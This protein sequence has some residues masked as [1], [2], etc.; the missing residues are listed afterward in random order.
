[1]GYMASQITSI[2][3]VYPTVYSRADRRKQ[4]SSVSLAFVRGIHRVPVNS[5]HKWPVTRK[6]FPFDDVFMSIEHLRASQKWAIRYSIALHYSDVI[7]SA[8]ASQINF[9][10][11]VCATICLDA[12]PRKKSKLRV[13]GFFRGIHQWSV[14]FPHR[15]PVTRKMFPF[16]DVFML[17]AWEKRMI[18]APP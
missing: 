15:G 12:D 10:S 11:I 13:T 5:P 3:I 6:M 2:T 18:W 17:P 8:I 16:G 9:V 7:M 4:Q 1:M 14:N